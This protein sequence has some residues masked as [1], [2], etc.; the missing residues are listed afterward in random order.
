MARKRKRRTAQ[1][2]NSSRYNR[3]SS[4]R[5]RGVDP[6]VWI[7]VVVGGLIVLLVLNAWQSGAFA[8]QPVPSREDMVNL[9]PLAQAGQ[10]LRGG[11]DTTMIP[12]QT[13]A[14]QPAPSSVLVP[15]LDIP[16]TS[17]DFG[18][19]YEAWDVTHTFAV[20]N[21]GDADLQISN[22]VTSC[23]CTTAEL[24]SSVIPPGQRTD[25]TVVFDAN[26]HPTSGE[27]T[28]LVWFATNDPTQPWVEMR[29]T[30]NVR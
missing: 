28:R 12:Q 14:P 20:Q 24:S 5:S 16:S 30:A 27:V 7:G 6:L 2:T 17:H 4:R 11:Y 21:T 10:P 3:K 13:P 26:F 25:L 18:D 15:Q 22:L 23:G 19:I 8:K 9:L 1:V 29:I